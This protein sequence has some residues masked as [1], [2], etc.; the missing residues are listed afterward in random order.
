MPIILN[1][2][3]VLNGRGIVGKW[4]NGNCAGKFVYRERIPN[5][6]RYRFYTMDGVTSISEAEENGTK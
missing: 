4:G 6:K 3:K 2:T 1:K 5:T